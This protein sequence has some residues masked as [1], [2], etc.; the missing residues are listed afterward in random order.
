MNENN[1]ATINFAYH[2]GDVTIYPDLIKV[3]VAMDSGD[4]VGFEAQGYHFSHTLRTIPSPKISQEEARKSLNERL[5][6]INSGMAIIPT[7]VKTE[8]LVYE[9]KGQVDGKE[10]IVY[11]NAETGNEEDILIVLNTPNGVLTI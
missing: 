9:F 5:N 1:I 10:F 3:Q 6:I 11:I 2:Q 4:I 8:V 7:D